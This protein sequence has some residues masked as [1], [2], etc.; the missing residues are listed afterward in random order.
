MYSARQKYNLS[1]FSIFILII[2]AAAVL[3]GC[4]KQTSNAA[5]SGKYE[6]LELRYQG[7]VNSVTYP[8]LAQ[9]LGYLDP[10]KLKWIGNTTSGPQDIQSTVT[11]DVDFGSAFNGAIVKL[12]AAGAPIKSVI[13]SY[14]VDK[15]TWS[16][17]FVLDNSPIKSARDLIGKKV[18][19]NTLGAHHEFMLKE[20]LRRNG[21]TEKEIN[22]VTLVA[23][24]PVNTEQSLR[25]KQIDVAVLGGILRDKALERGGIHALFSDYDLFGKFTAGS[26][27]MTD[28]FLK[29]NP[30]TAK[31]FVEGTAKAIEWARTT[32]REEVI[33]R[34]EKIINERGRNEDDSTIKYWK[35]TGIA[36]KGGV[37]SNKEFSVWE[38]W[39]VEDGELKKGQLKANELYTNK[40][41][42]FHK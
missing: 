31:K 32:P 11:G 2:T 4:G 17:F 22:Q 6:T 23:I 37:I 25:Q 38:N 34:Y 42:P 28:K 19:M 14:G 33:A 13:G 36:G 12:M 1:F 27:V 20:Y 35:S 18:G 26:Y 30:N 40:F 21:L 7:A 24:P 39:L 10:I 3:S 8:E 5:S 29:E 41:N 16:G 9:D 15:E